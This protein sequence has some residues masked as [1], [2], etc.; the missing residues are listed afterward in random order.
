MIG[1]APL[2]ASGT[3]PLPRREFAAFVGGMNGEY[4]VTST[5][6]KMGSDCITRG[7]RVMVVPE[8]LRE[9]SD[10]EAGR[11]LFA[12]RVRITNQSDLIVQVMRRHW[13]IVDA[14]GDRREVEGDGV[15]G[16]QPILEPGATFEYASYCP[17]STKWGTM[18]GS[19]LLGV[20]DGQGISID[21]EIVDDGATSDGNV[22]TPP[23]PSELRVRV[24]RFFLIAP[25]VVAA[26]RAKAQPS[27]GQ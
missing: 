1:H 18:E 25:E 7:I 20:L 23:I 3:L 22:G 16:R 24:G 19:F 13:I 2:L 5:A 11:Y 9:Q 15:V 8:F 17:L 12:Y 6:K 4:R 21:P 10:A 14:D 27:G 26:P